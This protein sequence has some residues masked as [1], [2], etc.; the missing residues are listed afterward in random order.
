MEGVAFFEEEVVIEGIVPWAGNAHVMDVV[1]CV[2]EEE[3]VKL[4]PSLE[5]MERK[6]NSSEQILYPHIGMM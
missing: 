3:N 1:E 4:G 5:P 2:L 6:V